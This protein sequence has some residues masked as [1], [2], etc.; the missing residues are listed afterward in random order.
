MTSENVLL[1]ANGIK[2]YFKGKNH[3]IIKANDDISLCI[4]EGEVLGIV[5][6]SGCGKS[7]FGRTLL[8]L[9]QATEGEIIY[10]PKECKQGIQLTKRKESELRKLRRELQ[11]V[12][13]DPYSSLDPRMS[14]GKSIMTNRG[15]M[16]EEISATWR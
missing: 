15:K 14:V 5:G 1:R 10:Y 4:Y 6:E 3:S 12:F 13:Q 2:M 16:I 11:M 8:C 9:Y 7:T